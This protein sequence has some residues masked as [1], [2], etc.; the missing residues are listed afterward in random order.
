MGPLRDLRPAEITL[1]QLRRAK[2]WPKL[3]LAEGTALIASA[4]H[5]PISVAAPARYGGGSKAC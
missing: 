4:L 2:V 5:R 3:R 1:D